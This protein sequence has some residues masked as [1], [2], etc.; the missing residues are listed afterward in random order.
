MPLLVSLKKQLFFLKK[1]KNQA[2]VPF[3]IFTFKLLVMF[4]ICT[5]LLQIL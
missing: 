1:K 4:T 2:S 3:D 5:I